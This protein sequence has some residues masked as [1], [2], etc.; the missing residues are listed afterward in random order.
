MNQDAQFQMYDDI[1]LH[2]AQRAIDSMTVILNAAL[3]EQDRGMVAFRASHLLFET[4]VYDAI[5][6]GMPVEIVQ[7][8]LDMV[9]RLARKAIE[10]R[11]KD[12][13]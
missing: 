5:K 13:A 2:A 8:A 10:E 11:E 3:D 6:H 7:G 1:A 4:M 9:A 12:A